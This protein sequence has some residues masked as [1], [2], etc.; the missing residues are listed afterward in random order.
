MQLTGTFCVSVV[1]RIVELLQQIG[2]Q[3]VQRL[4]LFLLFKMQRELLDQTE[5]LRFK[6]HLMMIHVVCSMQ[7]P[8]FLE[9]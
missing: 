5:M 1:A 3:F 6:L 7:T 9:S 8:N 2:T 4:D